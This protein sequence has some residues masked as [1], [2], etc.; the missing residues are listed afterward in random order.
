MSL[1]PEEASEIIG[2][3]AIQLERWAYL[4]QGPK[5]I[6]TKWKPRYDED[7]LREWLT[8]MPALSPENPEN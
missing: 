6:G 8:P 2:V 5:N 1:S 3:P 7:D 4:K